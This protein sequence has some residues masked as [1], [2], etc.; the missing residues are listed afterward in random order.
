MKWP[1]D[2]WFRV[3]GLKFKSELYSC[4]CNN[5]FNCHWSQCNCLKPFS[6]FKDLRIIWI[7]YFIIICIEKLV[8]KLMKNDG[9]STCK[10]KKVPSNELSKHFHHLTRITKTQFYNNIG[11]NTIFIYI[12]KVDLYILCNIVF[13]SGMILSLNYTIRERA[14]V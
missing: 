11:S 10:W 13:R 7:I 8:L 9:L 2:Y 5:T 12:N 1:S 6:V 3:E 4:I 14:F